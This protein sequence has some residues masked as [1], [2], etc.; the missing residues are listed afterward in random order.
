MNSQLFYMNV[1]RFK[2]NCLT[3]PCVATGIKNGVAKRP[4]L[5]VKTPRR[6]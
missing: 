1:Y 3:A 4:C 6:A 5:V 2:L